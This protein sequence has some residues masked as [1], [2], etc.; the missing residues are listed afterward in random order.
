MEELPAT[1]PAAEV[2]VYVDA[3]D[4]EMVV[5]ISCPVPTC[6]AGD[7]GAVWS[8][9]GPGDATCAIHLQ[10]HM[11][12]A[13]GAAAAPAERRPK[14][15][16]LPLPTLTSQC[17][18]AQFAEFGREWAQYKLS[19]DMATSSTSS[20]LIN[21]C[22]SDLRKDVS[23]ATPGI[24]A[25]TEDEVMA[26]IK[27]YAVQS[28]TECV[29]MKELLGMVQD[30]EEG[31]RRFYARV[32]NVARQ[33]DLEIACTNNV[34]PNRNAPFLSYRDKIVK[35]VVLNGLYHADM[36]KEVFGS[37]SYTHLTLPTICS[38]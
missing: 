23:A 34:C 19:V 7:A 14:P 28:R 25:L 24:T 11:G 36:Q 20:F 1:E 26:A 8:Y 3:S 10:Y 15:P 31:I 37:V 33:C 22:E 32:L 13:H 16:Q 30:Q 4:V 21:C 12:S 9:Q 27:T 35:Y 38:V 29:L 18:E 2:D 5:T 6:T 17:S